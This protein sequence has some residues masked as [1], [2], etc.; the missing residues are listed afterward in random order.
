MPLVAARGAA[1]EMKVRKTY[2]MLI[3]NDMDRA[4]HLRQIA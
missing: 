3:M 1:S 2:L 4:T